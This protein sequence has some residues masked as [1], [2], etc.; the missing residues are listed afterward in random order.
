MKLITLLVFALVSFCSI[1]QEQYHPRPK[2]VTEDKELSK[3]IFNYINDYRVNSVGVKP[4][5]WTDFWYKSAKKWNDYTSYNGKWGHNRGPEWENC[6]GTELIVAVLIAK[7]SDNN[8]KFIAD[9]ALQ[10]WLHS[11]SHRSGIECPL[12]EKLGDRSAQQFG[13]DHLSSV[14]L[15][16]YGAISANVLDFGDHKKVYI[17]FQTGFY[18][19]SSDMI[20]SALW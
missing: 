2:S 4:F 7:D 15:T 12:M 13:N 6:Y 19:N 8:Y 1:S 18:S 11:T 5:V 17:I 9:S 3:Y 20:P 10:Q 16:K 14:F